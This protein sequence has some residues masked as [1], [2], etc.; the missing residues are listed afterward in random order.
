MNQ[1]SMN[2]EAPVSTAEFL[3]PAGY[4]GLYGFHKYWG[5]KPPETVAF[6]LE[7]LSPVGGLVLDP[8]LGSG[9]VAREAVM[10]KRRFVGCDINPIAIELANLTLEPPKADAVESAYQ[11]LEQTVRAEIDAQYRMDSG[12]T[13]S[14][15]LWEEEQLY[16]VWMKPPKQRARRE[17]TPTEHD[18][19]LSASF[20]HYQP[21]HL[22]P[23]RLFQNSRIN[24]RADM[25][26]GDLFTGRALRSIE[27]LR[28]AIFEIADAEARQ[29]LMLA[30]TASVGQMSKM[31]FVIERRG[32]ARG[33]AKKPRMEVGSWVIGLWIPKRRF[34]INA[35]NCFANKVA[36]LIR[37]LRN[38]GDLPTNGCASASLVCNDAKHVLETLSP[39]SVDLVLTDPPHGDR[40]PYLEM[41]EIWNAIL[42]EQPDFH[43][44]LVVSNARERN[45]NLDAYASDLSAT[46][47]SMAP[48][49]T[50]DAIV[51]LM[52]NSRSKDEWKTLLDAMDAAG[53]AYQGRIPMAYSAGS[54]VQDSRKGALSS[55]YVVIYSRRNSTRPP[56]RVRHL[57]DALPQWCTRN[58]LESWGE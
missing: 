58:P 13:A 45:K 46:F 48:C 17:L 26:W 30:L 52:F 5:K 43:H 19:D 35:W 53:L 22:R 51:A 14:H 34:E 32:K 37:A 47:S 2:L 9:A 18:R 36:K 7:Q 50:D 40:I 54:V 6:L 25:H 15:Y 33:A 41:S 57:A 49:L 20:E 8:F 39:R 1:L 4:S 38:Q 21:R 29:A 27:L 28:S 10:R 3:S 23:L 24:A 44:E 55:D 56:P 42:D 11:H 12:E 31:V 16:A